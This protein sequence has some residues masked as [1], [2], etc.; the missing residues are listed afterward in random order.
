M[1]TVALF[2]T[3]ALIA[4]SC[5]GAP[6]PNLNGPKAARIH[7][8]IRTSG[9]RILDATG[10]AVRFNGVGVRDF[11]GVGPPGTRCVTTPSSKEVND[12]VDWGFNSVRVPLAWVHLEPNTPLAGPGGS[13]THAWDGEYLSSLDRFVDEVTSRGLAVIFTL[14][15]QFGTNTTKPS[16]CHVTSMPPWLYPGGMGDPKVAKCEFLEGITR[17]G[18]PE[19]IWEG[20]GAVWTMLAE[21][22]ANDPLVLG[23]DLANEPYAGGPCSQSDAKLSDLY[24]ELGE[25]IRRVNPDMAIIFEDA[26]PGAAEQGDFEVQ[27][28]PSV[29]NTIYSYHMYQPNWDPVGQAVNEAYWRRAREWGIPLIVGEFNAFGYA[30]P[31]AGYQP[32]WRSQTLRALTFW[33]AQGISWM[34]WSYS[35]GNHLIEKDGSPR[36]DLI[37]AFQRG[38]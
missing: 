31:G 25:A 13:L 22:Y 36:A 23:A 32:D 38:Y 9:T 21:R 12:I 26:P 3:L 17:S 30:A 37:S 14:H 15:N 16:P 8:P 29:P 19:S 10:A 11:V 5:H 24:Q 20:Y 35:G 2:A 34:A 28:P 1:A 33:K 4:A 18:A 7:P 27:Q 6:S